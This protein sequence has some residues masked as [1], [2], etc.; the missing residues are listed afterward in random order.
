MD[1]I[2]G[3]VRQKEEEMAKKCEDLAAELSEAKVDA[4]AA[5][6]RLAGTEAELE[7]AEKRA[8][9][10]EKSMGGHASLLLD[11]SIATG[12]PS[13]QPSPVPGRGSRP[14]PPEAWASEGPFSPRDAAAD[15]A[16]ATKDAS[17][18][19]RRSSTRRRRKRE[20]ERY[21]EKAALV[22]RLQELGG[23]IG[24]EEA[25]LR[26]SREIR[27]EHVLAEVRSELS[28]FASHLLMDHSPEPL[29][30][31]APSPRNLS[32]VSEPRPPTEVR[33]EKPAPRRAHSLS[34]SLP[35]S[36]SQL[37]EDYGAP[38]APVPSESPRLGHARQ[39]SPKYVLHTVEEGKVHGKAEEP[40]AAQAARQLG[41]ASAALA[42]CLSSLD[43]SLLASASQKAESD[44]HLRHLGGALSASSSPG[45]RS[46]TSGLASPKPRSSQVFGA[47]EE[48]NYLRTLA[49]A[50]SLALRSIS[51]PALH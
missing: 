18:K 30:L 9:E 37:S 46:W 20:A 19:K 25:V 40:P 31:M 41:R 23:I 32:T 45:S 8:A 5:R 4:A 39:G 1:T 22:A 42:D 36:A 10:L 2:K 13:S 49:T 3:H 21:R 26:E 16:K 12:A 48:S 7:G 50:E 38:P 28:S 6:A 33:F 47:R 15:G 27:R 43:S 24:R 14:H 44:L 11:A 17:D 34:M 35:I 51:P 29:H